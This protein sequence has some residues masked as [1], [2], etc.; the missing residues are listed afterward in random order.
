MDVT[1]SVSSG[2]I[3]KPNTKVEVSPPG[4]HKYYGFFVEHLG[5][6]NMCRVLIIAERSAKGKVTKVPEDKRYSYL[7][8]FSNLTSMEL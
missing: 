4:N 8:K 7:T 5:F 6:D 2:G 3:M 1:T